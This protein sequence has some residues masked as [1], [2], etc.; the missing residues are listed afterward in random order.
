MPVPLDA[1]G[2][3]R[4]RRGRAAAS[5]RRA[6][7]RRERRRR[8]CGFVQLDPIR[9]P[10]RAA[11]LILR[12]RVDG[13]RAGDLDRAYPA[14]AL[15]EDYLHVYGVIRRRRTR[16]PASAQRARCAF[17]SSASTRGSRRACSRTSRTHGETHPRDLVALGTPSTTGGWGSDSVGDDA[18]AR[19][20]AFPRQAARRAP[21]KRHQGLCARA[22]TAPSRSPRGARA[23]APA[24]CC[25]TS[26]RRCPRR[27]LRQLACMVTESSTSPALRARALA[28]LRDARDVAAHD[29]DGVDVAVAGGRDAR[30]ESTSSACASSRRSI[31]WCGTAAASSASGAGG[32]VSRR[33][34]RPPSASSATTRCRCCGATT[35]SAG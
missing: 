1:S 28:A 17:A 26:T 13:Y 18:R 14:S 22:R 3:M 34:R 29:V 19:S 21:R 2:R 10:A 27:R 6:L 11:D 15:V 16:T 4:R 32:T 31:R 25:S 23:G 9:A 12:Q 30:G 7:D 35:S 5:P 8:A 20:A 24:R 33:T